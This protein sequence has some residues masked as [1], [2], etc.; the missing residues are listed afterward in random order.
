MSAVARL[1]DGG[2]GHGAFVPRACIQGSAN[3]F[4]N[5]LAV[6]RQ[7]DAWAV[8]CDPSLSC[9]SGVLAKGSMTVFVNGVAIGRVGD[10]V[11]CGSLIAAGSPNVF[12]GG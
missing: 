4:C 10:S 2:T 11:D 7:G 1:G 9:H 3:V 5:G 6:H 8:H 12:A